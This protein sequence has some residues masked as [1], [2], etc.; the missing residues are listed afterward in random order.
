MENFGEFESWTVY[1]IGVCLLVSTPSSELLTGCLGRSISSKK[2]NG[3]TG[4]NSR[5]VEI[6]TENSVVSSRSR[7]RHLGESG[8]KRLDINDSLTTARGGKTKDSQHTVDLNVRVGRPDTN[9]VTMLIGHTS[10]SNI[11]LDVNAVPVAANSEKLFG[12]EDRGRIR[13]F[14]P[15]APTGVLVPLAEAR[16]AREDSSP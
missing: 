3:L 10:T 1:L 14:T 13:I 12:R 15:Y 16:S 6:V 5:D 2:S 8:I 11:K 7:E 4:S 9:M